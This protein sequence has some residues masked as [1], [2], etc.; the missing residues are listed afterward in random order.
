MPFKLR[1][2]RCL[3]SAT[4]L[5]VLFYLGNPS[6]PG[7][8]E[9]APWRGHYLMLVASLKASTFTPERLELFDKSP[10]D[11][12]AIQFVGAYETIPPPSATQMVAQISGAKKSTKKDLWPWVNLNR[13]VG[14]DPNSDNHYGQDPYFYRIQGA[15]LENKSGAQD[16]FIQIW[17]NSLRAARDVKA[18]G[19][20]VDLEFYSNYK[21][22]DPFV[23]AKQVGIS[24]QETQDLLKKV[25]A[26][27][28][29]TAAKEYPNAVL[30]FLF[31]D[32]GQLGDYVVDGVKYYPSPAYVVMGLL[33]EIRAKGYHLK[34]IDGGEVGIEYCSLNLSHLRRKIDDQAKAFAPHL[35]RYKSSL[36]LAGTMILW[37]DRESKMDFMATGPC[38]KSEA[39]TVEDL[40]PYLE[41]I[42]KSY[43]YNWIYATYYAGYDP[44]HPRSAPRFD[45]M[46]RKAEANAYGDSSR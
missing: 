31:T 6:T 38:S 5:F 19:I 3:G 43:R 22:Y 4:I 44:F 17:Q 24:P 35:E 34:V 13:M 41:M 26:R 10:Y 37:K 28:A 8:Q 18:P 9:K 39:A 20:T 1:A 40:Q 23:L 46:I 30:W 27:M 14:R 2:E 36:E 33:E 29:D 12:V 15:D 25:G 45:A 11:G 16:D 32:L 7:V 21:A 42:L